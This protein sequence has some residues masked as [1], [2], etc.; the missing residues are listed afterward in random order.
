MSSAVGGCLPTAF[1]LIFNVGGES[2]NHSLVIDNLTGD[3]S[4]VTRDKITGC[5]KDVAAIDAALRR[6][7]NMPSS[8]S[9]TPPAT[10]VGNWLSG[11][12]KR[13]RVERHGIGGGGR[14]RRDG[15]RRADD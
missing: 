7:A 3:A 12:W 15:Q 8:S 11:R 1:A 9:P 6:L 13:R 2:P 14:R 10:V 4:Y 5:I